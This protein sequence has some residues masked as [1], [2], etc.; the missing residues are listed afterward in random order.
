MEV[1][2]AGGGE[3]S[4]IEDA[5]SVRRGGSRWRIQVP[6]GQEDRRWMIRLLEGEEDQMVE[7]V[8]LR[9]KMYCKIVRFFYA[10][11]SLVCRFLF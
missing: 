2:G 8:D 9:C 6:E 3:R 11:A 7:E 4:T 1:T 5:G 10:N